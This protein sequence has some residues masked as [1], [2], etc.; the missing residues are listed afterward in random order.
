MGSARVEVRNGGLKRID[1]A[2]KGDW[3]KVSRGWR[4]LQATLSFD[5]GEGR[6]LWETEEG[7]RTTADHPVIQ[8]AEWVR[9]QV[10]KGARKV[11]VEENTVYSVVLV[12]HTEG[13]PGRNYCRNA[14]VA[15]G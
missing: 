15:P 11:N 14:T 4:K 9:A 2:C 6:A 12:E 8:G 10:V 1:G 13:E 7:V 5:L 3:I